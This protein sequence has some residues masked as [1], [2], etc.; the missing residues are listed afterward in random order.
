MAKR[1]RNASSIDFLDNR[2]ICELIGT[3]ILVL[4]GCGTIVLS[5]FGAPAGALQVGTAF[6]LAFTAVIYSVGAISGGHINPAVSIA[7][8]TA[9]RMSWAN[10][11]MYIVYQLIGAL[12][13]AGILWLIVKGKA[14]APAAVAN[15]GQNVIMGGYSTAA[16]I[17]VE[18]VATL[19][20][21]LVFL[22][23]TGARGGGAAIGGLIIG[24]TLV[25]LHLVFISV[26]GLSVN[27]ARSF[28]PAILVG[29]N[30]LAQ[31]WL[32]IVAPLAGGAL[33][34]LLYRFKILKI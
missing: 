15:L 30:A 7:M 9:G 21:V 16:V 5:G 31:L 17:G 12:I 1:S 22:G 10:A 26:D 34:G 24:L 3:A 23:A 2:Y 8:A 6:G 20:F 13:G 33:G 28:G 29:G 4:V 25:A 18:F 32:F 19:I 14:G 11:V 27:P